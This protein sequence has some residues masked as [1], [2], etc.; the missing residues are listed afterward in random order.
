MLV[1]WGAAI[2]VHP[3]LIPHTLHWNLRTAR[4]PPF[5]TSLTDMVPFR[6]SVLKCLSLDGFFSWKTF[7]FCGALAV[8][9]FEPSEHGVKT[10]GTLPAFKRFSR[11]LSLA[12]PLRFQQR[13]SLKFHVLQSRLRRGSVAA[14]NINPSGSRN[15]RKEPT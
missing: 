12:G 1:Q 11:P 8:Q 7:E 6:K 14:S 3:V 9:A 5:N 4:L 13:K 2:M 15:L 10:R